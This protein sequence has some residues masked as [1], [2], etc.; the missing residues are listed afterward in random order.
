MAQIYKALLPKFLWKHIINYL[1][2]NNITTMIVAN[3]DFVGVM[4]DNDWKRCFYDGRKDAI[5]IIKCVCKRIDNFW[6]YACY[7]YIACVD[8]DDML[9]FIEADNITAS[10]FI[11]YKIFIKEG[12]YDISKLSKHYRFNNTDCSIEI[13][14]S[15]RY[16]YK[17]IF[18][19]PNKADAAILILSK[20]FS[21][22]YITFCYTLWLSRY[23]HDNKE[24]IDNSNLEVKISN[25]IF[26][27]SRI[28]K[29]LYVHSIDKLV[30]CDVQFKNS[31]CDLE[32]VNNTTMTNCIF[33]NSI[34]LI[35]AC[36]LEVNY[37]IKNNLFS[38]IQSG[39]F[40]VRP[41]IFYSGEWNISS[42]ILFCNNTVKNTELFML[43]W[44][45]DDFCVMVFEDNL[46][47]EV[48]RLI[49]GGTENII[50][51]D[52]SNIFTNCTL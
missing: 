35:E 26:S 40:D 11:Y 17:T 37:M 47:T 44:S 16:Q 50:T 13:T 4:D 19:N 46:F 15:N 42:R 52:K 48:I 20:Y 30:I 49:R 22:K 14:G 45:R 5:V 29:G 6:R 39:M 21:I 25:C 41:A 2:T 12:R 43:F 51:M 10:S 27:N 3:N 7:N 31:N 9:S 18:S 24:A 28:I 32:L 34:L 38:N 36:R 1:S 33:D 8:I 23:D